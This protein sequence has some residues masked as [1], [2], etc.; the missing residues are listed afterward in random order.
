MPT[1]MPSTGR[2]PASRSPMIR[3]PRTAFR[4]CHARGEG[5]DTGHHQPVR[6]ERGLGVRG[7]LDVGADP[8]QRA[9]GG[10]EVA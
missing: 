4:P 6:V 9:L 10:A 3:A 7:H 1:Q 5:A 8:P 2:P